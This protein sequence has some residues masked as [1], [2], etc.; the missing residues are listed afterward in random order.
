MHETAHA[1][2][3]SISKE[4]GHRCKNRGGGGG[5]HYI[6]SSG[7][8]PYGPVPPKQLRNHSYTPFPFSFPIPSW[9]ITYMAMVPE[10]IQAFR[11]YFY[12]G[13]QTS[14]PVFS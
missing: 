7:L 3:N 12:F 4:D 8:Q 14:L 5:G 10:L 9:I 1:H 2:I 11:R 6:A 13:N